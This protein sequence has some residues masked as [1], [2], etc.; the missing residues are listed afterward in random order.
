MPKLEVQKPLCYADMLIRRYPGHVT[1]YVPGN[2][3]PSGRNILTTINGTLVSTQIY[4][5]KTYE[6]I[7]IP[8]SV[9]HD[10]LNE[11]RLGFDTLDVGYIWC[12]L[13]YLK[14]DMTSCESDWHPGMVILLR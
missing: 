11:V 8:A 10:G 9:L 12:N 1:A 3:S 6:A 14:L 4:G 5:N 13:Y 7:D 2:Y